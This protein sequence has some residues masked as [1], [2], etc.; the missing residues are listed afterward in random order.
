MAATCARDVGLRDAEDGAI[1]DAARMA[2]A[3]VVS[4]DEDFSELVLRRGPPPQLVWL[5]CGN[6]SNKHLI[7][8][9]EKAWDEVA[10]QVSSGE[11]IVEL[12]D[13]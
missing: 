7:E 2:N 6:C 9:F 1:F 3:V 11:P 12:V 13:E 5:R 10:L 8:L 4:K